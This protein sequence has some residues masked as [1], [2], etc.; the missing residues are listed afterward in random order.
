MP[1]SQIIEDKYING[2]K[3]DKENDECFFND[4]EHKYYNKADM[5]PYI[6]VTQLIGKYCEEFDEDFWSSY[7]AAEALLDMDTWLTLKKVLLAKK[8]FD[9]K[10]ISKL[11]MNE[12][13]FFKKKQEIL[14]SY[15]AKREEACE[16]GTAQHLKKE[17][18]FYDRKD[19]DFGRYGFKD[20][21][22]VF[23]CKEDY[24]KLDTPKGVYP[25]F[26]VSVTSKDGLLRVSGQIDC[27]IKDENDIYIIDW[28]GLD[29]N[30]PILTMNG[31]KTMGT[32]TL[33]DQ[34]FDRDGNPVNITHVSEVHHNPCYELTF[35]T[36]ETLI[37]DEEH[38]WLVAYRFKED[39]F[40]EKVMTTKQIKSWVETKPDYS[41]RIYNPAPLNL[42][43]NKLL[44]DP[45]VL[46]V[47]LAIGFEDCSIIPA[48]DKQIMEELD[49]KGYNFKIA[50]F[51]KGTHIYKSSVC[52]GTRLNKLNLINNKHI[53]QEYLMASY[54]DRLALLRGIMD[55]RGIS[56]AFYKSYVI[57]P[58]NPNETKYLSELITSFGVKCG[59]FTKKGKTY[60]RWRSLE[61]NPFLVK[62]QDKA[63]KFTDMERD[64]HYYRRV[65]SVKKVETVPTRCIEVD[66]PTH[67]Y[68]AGRGLIPTHNTNAKIE[69]ESYYNRATKSRQMMKYP[70]NNLQDCT[71]NHYACQ[72]SLYAYMLQQINPNFEIKGLK[73]IHIDRNENET[74]LD[75]PYL[76]DE[77]E[78]MLKHYKKQLKM[79]MELDKDIPYIK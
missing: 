62:F 48:R 49:K 77:V 56:W 63:D 10:I 60:I 18:S 75:V 50:P 32:L 71:F 78:K 25:E 54:E 44:I 33:D 15:K 43:K 45:Y 5:K 7:K 67:T 65:V 16:H 21:K 39:C 57:V 29:V 61:I 64:M 30:T 40:P 37:A 70:L 12:E 1:K 24:F 26:L 3:V 23:D 19:F 46:G 47:W 79:K 11:G 42:P 35:D 8:K 38:R 4:A 14:D 74:E 73:I 69:K 28:K 34:V 27:L 59:L 13:E 76:K 6:S 2:I 68:L 20:L 55:A 51:S 36:G 17:L 72:L 22:G 52:L 53:P 31:W 58:K 9:N 41:I 66:S